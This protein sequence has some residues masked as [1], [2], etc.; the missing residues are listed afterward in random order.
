[1]RLVAQQNWFHEAH[2]QADVFWLTDAP[3]RVE[4]HTRTK[5]Y[6]PT[7]Y[8]DNAIGHAVVSTASLCPSNPEPLSNSPMASCDLGG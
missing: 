8:D 1:M 5:P 6:I 3:V 2:S 4:I 7:V